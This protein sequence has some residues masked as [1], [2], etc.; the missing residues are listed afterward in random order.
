METTIDYCPK[1]AERC[2]LLS[3][4][5]V[6]HSRREEA[7]YWITLCAEHLLAHGDHKDMLFYNV[8]G[9][10]E[11]YAEGASR[12]TAQTV[13]W[14][15]LAQ[16]APAIAA[17]LDYTNGDETRSFPEDFAD[18]LALAAPEK[19]SAYY[20]W[21]CDRGDHHH[22]L[23]TLHSF[24][25]RADLSE[26]LGQ[27][28]AMTAIDQVSLGIIARRA[29]EGDTGA[30]MVRV[31]QQVYLGAAVFAPPDPHKDQRSPY[32]GYTNAFD[33]ARYPPE[34]FDL[35]LRESSGYLDKQYIATWA[36]YWVSNG[37]KSEVYRAL[38]DADERGIDIRCYD[39][40]F[41]LALTLYGKARAYPWLVKAHIMGSGWS[42]RISGQNEVEQRWQLIKRH[43]PDHWQAFLQQTLMQA[44]TWLTASFSQGEFRRLI[45]YCLLMEQRDLAQRLIDQM[46]KRSLEFV[47]MLPLPIPEWVNT[48]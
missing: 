13:I 23:S 35:Y 18:A 44:P 33:P 36:E 43:Y 26:A 14:P 24:L 45:E 39:R 37:N 7:R 29:A 16:L 11:R 48:A 38:A 4:L 31:R 40:L 15:W 34:L 47:S 20:N 21:Q 22:A 12:T 41:A 19:L 2:A 27:S 10:I 42:W 30:Q 9:A 6:L 28:L 32:E 8:L 46:V 17:I 1:R 25:E 5:A 3:A